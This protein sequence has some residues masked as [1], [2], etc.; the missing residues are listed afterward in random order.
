MLDGHERDRDAG[1]GA[2]GRTPD[3]RA[4]QHALALDRP[5]VG[6]HAVHAAV[7]DVE[8]GDADTA[9]ERHTAGRRLPRERRD[10]PHRLRDAVARDE[11]RPE[12]RVRVEQRDPLGRLV[13]REQVRVRDPVRPSEPLP[14]PQLRH[15][16]RRRRDLDAADPVP[17][18]QAVQLQRPVEAHGVLRDPAHRARA[19]RLE[20]QAGG[21][22]G[23]AAGLEQRPLVD[24]EDVGRAELRQV[25]GGARPDDA[26]ADDDRLR[27]VAHPVA[28]RSLGRVGRHQACS[29]NGGRRVLR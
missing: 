10:D 4:D 19:V 3:P 21:M 6:L 15:P 18:R 5:A 16:L 24:H 8:A 17:T 11:V 1:Q 22:R 7:P 13:R 2:D 9:L 12:D 28:F 29:R 25:V 26:R 20:H 14:P 23:G 27:P